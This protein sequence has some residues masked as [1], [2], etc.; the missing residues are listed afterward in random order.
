MHSGRSDGAEISGQLHRLAQ[1]RASK[2]E[3]FRDSLVGFRLSE[4]EFVTS[5]EDSFFF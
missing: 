1:G 2:G 4:T 5:G 3:S